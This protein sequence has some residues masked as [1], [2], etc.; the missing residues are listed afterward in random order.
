MAKM[1]KRLEDDEV[2]ARKQR[3]KDYQN[4]R[5]ERLKELGEKKY[6]LG[7]I[8]MPMKNWRTYVKVWGI[9]DQCRECTTL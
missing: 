3:D 2:A 8:M 6:Q 7:L 9:K 5:Q 4:R 1:E